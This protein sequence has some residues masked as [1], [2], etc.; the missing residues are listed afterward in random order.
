M[1]NMR[2]AIKFALKSEIVEVIDFLETL[3]PEWKEIPGALDL[4]YGI[5]NEQK[6]IRKQV[7]VFWDNVMALGFTRYAPGVIVHPAGSRQRKST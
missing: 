2:P 4:C 7:E 6:I 3:G 5:K 1:I